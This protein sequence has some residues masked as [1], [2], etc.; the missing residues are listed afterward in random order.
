MFTTPKT[1]VIRSIG[2]TA[3][4]GGLQSRHAVDDVRVEICSQ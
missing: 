4:T 3:S 2:F 1:M